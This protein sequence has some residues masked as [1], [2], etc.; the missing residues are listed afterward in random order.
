M[1]VSLLE[2]YQT[3]SRTIAN[4]SSSSPIGLIL[5]GGLSRRMGRNKALVPW[6]NGRLI[7]NAIERLTP[8]TSALLI[9]TNQ[10]ISGCEGIVQLPDSLPD[11]GPLAGVLSGLQW[12]QQQKSPSHWLLTVAVDTPW[13]PLDFAQQ[14]LHACDRDNDIIAA[15][16][17]QRQH[18]TCAL[19]H[20]R[21]LPALQDY[22]VNQQQRRLMAFIDSRAHQYVNFATNAQDPFENLNNP[23]DL[24]ASAASL[25][26]QTAPDDKID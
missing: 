14:L 1:A 4:Q 12:M 24:S 25:A 15:R 10:T 19:W 11:A 20:R 18:P 3:M 17:D 23:S 21:I 13:F 7:D 2:F 9:S 16:S 26:N 5:A 6:G 8:Q 22:L